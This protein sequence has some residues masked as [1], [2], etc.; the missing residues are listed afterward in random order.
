M[1]A[2]RIAG[3][4]RRLCSPRTAALTVIT[5][6]LV[7]AG[8]ATASII[9]PGADT[10]G[11]FGPDAFAWD[12]TPPSLPITVTDPAGHQRWT[13]RKYQSKDGFP[14]LEV[15]R[16]NG[17]EDVVADFGRVNADKTFT[18]LP[19]ED[20]GSPINLSDASEALLVNHYRATA[21]Q[22]AHVAIFGMVT[23]DVQNVILRLASGT[24]T[25]PVANGV[26]L[27]VLPEA[28]LQGAEAEF[29]RSDGTSKT[30]K[31]H[32]K[33]PAGSGEPP[34]GL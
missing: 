5:V 9:R 31:L 19:I 28:D 21:T 18:P 33:P 24:T 30:Y 13:V 25:A 3:R 8:V 27:A 20:G 26:F 15:G 6:L 23:G 10:G 32:S 1:N 22:A 17:Q 11:M 34:S 4:I 14:C 2:K 12:G 29:N 7:A 16:L